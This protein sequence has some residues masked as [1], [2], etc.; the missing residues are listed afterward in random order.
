MI[1]SYDYEGRYF[2][3]IA[4]AFSQGNNMLGLLSLSCSKNSIWCK[5]IPFESLT[6]IIPSKKRFIKKHLEALKLIRD[7]KPDLIQTHLFKAG[8]VGLIYGKILH[9]KVIL[10]RH[11]IDEHVQAGSRMHRFLDRIS[12]KL[13]DHVVVFSKAAK[14]WLVE[15]EGIKPTKITVINQGFYFEDLDSTMMEIAQAK[16]ELYFDLRKFNIVC[17]ARYSRTKGQEF[18]LKAVAQLLALQYDLSLTF[19]GPGDPMWL[20]KIANELKIEKMINFRGSRNDI[21]A[22]IGAADLIVHPSLVD[23][24]SQLIIEVQ[25]AGAALIATDIAAAREQIIDGVTGVIVPPRDSNSLA[26]SIALLY[27]DGEYLENLG[28]AGRKHVREKFTLERMYQEH[29]AC[30]EGV[31][32]QQEKVTNIINSKMLTLRNLMTKPWRIR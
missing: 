29:I 24:F 7:F 11:H 3:D 30:I 27:H 23:S 18:L 21:P 19:I 8:L 22:C 20:K 26:E 13:S 16:A 10:T 12:A 15:H 14:S 28:K 31:L 4:R 6:I 9:V 2:R 25:A 17:I 32:A 5:E 1:T